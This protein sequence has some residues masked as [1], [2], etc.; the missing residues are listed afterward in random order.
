MGQ[1]AFAKGQ[2]NRL[3]QH[4]WHTAIDTGR[5]RRG[6]CAL[7]QPCSRP[8]TNTPSR[9]VQGLTTQT[10]NREGLMRIAGSPTC[11]IQHPQKRSEDSTYRQAQ[12]QRHEEKADVGSPSRASD[13]GEQELGYPIGKRAPV[14][15]DRHART[16]SS[17]APQKTQP[18]KSH[19]I[20][21]AE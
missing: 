15:V 10:L 21:W 9:A 19:A 17:A 1:A 18:K 20:T 3:Q 12:A 11:C 6:S 4:D 7:R 2:L 13:F 16:N 8:Q 5:R 14:L